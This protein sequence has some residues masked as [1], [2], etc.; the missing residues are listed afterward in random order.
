MHA[1]AA[2]EDSDNRVFDAVVDDGGK[3]K[4]WKSHSPGFR[5]CPMFTTI[6]LLTQS[7]DHDRHCRP[8]GHAILS[9][10]TFPFTQPPSRSVSQWRKLCIITPLLNI[11]HGIIR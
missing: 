3:E 2:A 9:G 11:G 6:R 8:C 10:A 4:V 7:H 5:K 1:G